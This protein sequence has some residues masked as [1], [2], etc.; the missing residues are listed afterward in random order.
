MF[1][2]RF[3]TS[4]RTSFSSDLVIERGEI[5]GRGGRWSSF[6]VGCPDWIASGNILPLHQI[7]VGD[8]P[9][10]KATLQLTSLATDD[11]Q[12]AIYRIISTMPRLSRAIRWTPE[13]PA[14]RAGQLRVAFRQAMK[15][16]E[17][18]ADAAKANQ[19]IS[20]K[21]Q[22]DVADAV[23]DMANAPVE[24]CQVWQDILKG[25]K[26]RSLPPHIVWRDNSAGLQYLSPTASVAYCFAWHNNNPNADLITA[27]W[28]LLAQAA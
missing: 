13:V 12:R 3:N 17:L 22:N 11:R 24:N 1:H 9:A 7:G 23:A 16:P 25:H 2:G 28:P 21:A 4:G 15:A 8:D 19:E 5:D 14:E 20:P 26:Y 18:L 27:R 10:M 6:V